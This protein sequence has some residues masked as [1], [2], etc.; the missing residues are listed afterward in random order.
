MHDIKHG[1]LH[2]SRSNLSEGLLLRGVL[3][4]GTDAQLA[5]T[6]GEILRNVSALNVSPDEEESNSRSSQ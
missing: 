3:D 4:V 2:G 1:G 5:D 6:V